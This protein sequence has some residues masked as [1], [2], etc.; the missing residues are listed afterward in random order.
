M[1]FFSSAYGLR[2]PIKDVLGSIYSQKF[3]HYL[4]QRS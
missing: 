2:D 3:T 1:I 4:I